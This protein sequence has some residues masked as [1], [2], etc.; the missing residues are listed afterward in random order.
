VELIAGE[1]SPLV[2]ISMIINGWGADNITVKM[3]DKVLE[4]KRD[5]WI[6]RRSGLYGNDLIIWIEHESFRT[7][8]ID[9]IRQ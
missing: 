8:R 2:N 6:G 3:N 1:E 4:E 5:F 7:S 9:I